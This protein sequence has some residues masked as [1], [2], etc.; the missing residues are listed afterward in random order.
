MVTDVSPQQVQADAM[1]GRGGA[2]VAVAVDVGSRLWRATAL[3]WRRA[4]RRVH[5]LRRR[6]LATRAERAGLLAVDGVARYGTA[7]RTLLRAPERTGRG[8]RPRLAWPAGFALVQVVKAGRA[9]GQGIVRRVVVGTEATVA[10]HGGATI[11]TAYI[12][13]RNA[14]VREHLAPPGRRRRTPAQSAALGA[15][16]VALL[17]LAYNDC[18]THAS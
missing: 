11:N 1:R 6:T 12:E 13:R 16:G 15:S 5:R 17:R 18:W 14:T 2:A 8:G 7:A 10:S 9:R 3:A 4:G